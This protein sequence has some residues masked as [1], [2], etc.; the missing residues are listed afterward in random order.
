M[1][2]KTNKKNPNQLNAKPK[3]ADA[4]PKTTDIKKIHKTLTK[5]SGSLWSGQ[6]KKEKKSNAQPKNRDVILT[7]K[8][9]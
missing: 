9:K 2:T 5:R 4:K 8:I 3:T 6:T 1:T 7:Q